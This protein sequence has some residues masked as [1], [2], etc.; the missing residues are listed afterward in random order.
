VCVRIDDGCVQSWEEHWRPITRGQRREPS[1]EIRASPRGE[2]T[3]DCLVSGQRS[4]GNKWA[5][6]ELP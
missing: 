3:R 5:N 6:L 1:S 2:R 4:S